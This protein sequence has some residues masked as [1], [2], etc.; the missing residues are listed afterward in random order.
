MFIELSFNFSRASLNILCLLFDSASSDAKLLEEIEGETAII[1]TGWNYY[2]H[3]DDETLDALETYGYNVYR[4]DE[5]GD[6]EIRVGNSYVEKN[7]KD[8]YEI[9]LPRRDTGT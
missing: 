8:R 2:G 4:T 6:I 7:W 1:S 5:L 9:K 3:P